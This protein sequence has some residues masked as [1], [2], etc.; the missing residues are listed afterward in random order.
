MYLLTLK[1]SSL[2]TPVSLRGKRYFPQFQR[3]RAEYNKAYR[4]ILPCLSLRVIS[5]SHKSTRNIKWA[6]I[7]AYCLCDFDI[8]EFS[9]SLGDKFHQRFILILQQLDKL[10]NVVCF[11]VGSQCH[12]LAY[13][14]VHSSTQPESF[15]V[16]IVWKDNL[17][18]S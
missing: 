2:W 13:Q 4:H 14:L 11:S 8:T 9:A 10:K 5:L 12:C 1:Q 15:I 17:S 18:E 3:T 6:S 7:L 16:I